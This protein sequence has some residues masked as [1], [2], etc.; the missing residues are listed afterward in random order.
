MV[1][2]TK[3]FDEN[4]FKGSKGSSYKNYH[5]IGNDVYNMT[6]KFLEKFV[7]IEKIAPSDYSILV[8]GCAYGYE[9]KA[10]K[11]MG[12]KRVIG[13]DI[14]EHAIAEAKRTFSDIEF[15]VGDACNLNFK[16]NE[17]DI[18]MT[19][20]LLEHLPDPR[21]ALKEFYRVSRK[22]VLL[23]QDNVFMIEMFNCLPIFLRKIIS[24]LNNLPAELDTD[25]TH[26][27][28]LPMYKWIQLFKYY[29]F[30]VKKV[31]SITKFP[32]LL[33]GHH[34]YILEVIK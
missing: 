30:K 7:N 10:C 14:S 34:H 27:S 5:K 15:Y 11:D 22:Y 9:C 3:E 21:V 8:V 1:E 13:V 29:N 17:F 33:T 12:F 19:N 24:G 18:I 32:V 31:F 25:L 4:Y 16:D 2:A 23:R 28:Q 6:I 20:N 26:I